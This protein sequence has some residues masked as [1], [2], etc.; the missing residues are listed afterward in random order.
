MPKSEILPLFNFSLAY[1]LLHLF[2]SGERKN[3]VIKKKIELENTNFIK[4]SWKPE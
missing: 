1:I 3:G 2:L 4:G